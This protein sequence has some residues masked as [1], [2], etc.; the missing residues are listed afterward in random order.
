MPVLAYNILQ[1]ISILSIGAR[2]LGEK[3]VEGVTADLEK[4]AFYVDQ[5]LAL[6]TYLVPQLGYDQAADISKKAHTTGK[7][8]AE[9]VL[10]EGLLT[11]EELAR[12]FH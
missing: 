11:E 1:S 8:I 4:C 3:C 6:V 7:S 5:S 9:V 12:T 2:S 10:E